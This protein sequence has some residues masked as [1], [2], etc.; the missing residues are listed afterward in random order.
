MERVALSEVN[1]FM[2]PWFCLRKKK[3]VN[4]DCALIIML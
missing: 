3:M 1:W 2:E 4:C